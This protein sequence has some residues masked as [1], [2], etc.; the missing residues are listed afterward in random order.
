MKKLLCADPDSL[1]LYTLQM[2]SNKISREK[3]V[4]DSF[5]GKVIKEIN[6]MKSVLR[7]DNGFWLCEAKELQRFQQ[8]KKCIYTIKNSK[9]NGNEKNG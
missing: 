4:P 8:I 6:E 2:D 9:I 7:L 5:R 1:Q 3:N